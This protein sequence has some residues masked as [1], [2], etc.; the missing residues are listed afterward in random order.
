ML[1]HPLVK[2]LL[3]ASGSKI[4]TYFDGSIER[5]KTLL[6]AKGYFQEYEIDYEVTFVLV[7]S[8]TFVRNLLVVARC[9]IVALLQIDVKKCLPQ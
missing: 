4:K 3:A 6:V 8:M 2:E 9:Q 5:Y 7:T 1:I